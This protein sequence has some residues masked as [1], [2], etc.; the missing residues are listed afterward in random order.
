[1]NYIEMLLL[2]V[3]L[4]LA[5][6]LAAGAHDIYEEMTKE[7]QCIC[8]NTPDTRGGHL[9]EPVEAIPI[10]HNQYYLPASGE[11]IPRNMA[12]QSPD[13]RFHRCTYPLNKRWAPPGFAPA[14][15]GAQY[16]Q[17]GAMIERQGPEAWVVVP[18]NSTRDGKPATRCFWAPN[19]GW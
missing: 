18:D 10:D 3:T 15:P 5:M 14:Y 13:E 12:A 17:N 11:T 16:E 6:M 1:M 19:V 7:S 8:G 4:L 9:C 2:T